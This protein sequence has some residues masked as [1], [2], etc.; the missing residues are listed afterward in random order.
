MSGNN[1]PKYTVVLLSTEML[2]TLNFIS[3]QEPEPIHFFQTA[4]CYQSLLNV[5]HT[6]VCCVQRHFSFF[7]P[8]ELDHKMID[9]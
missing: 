3:S 6:S 7:V 1:G 8:A 4:V 2:L 5:L 9:G